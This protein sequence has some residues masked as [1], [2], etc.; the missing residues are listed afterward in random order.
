MSETVFISDNSHPVDDDA[1]NKIIVVVE[2]RCHCIVRGASVNWRAIVTGCSS[3]WARA[4]TANW[5]LSRPCCTTPSGWYGTL[6]IVPAWSARTPPAAGHRPGQRHRA[7]RMAGYRRPA[8]SHDNLTDTHRPS[9]RRILFECGGGVADVSQSSS[10]CRGFEAASDTQWEIWPV[11]T[12]ACDS[13]PPAVISPLIYQRTPPVAR[14]GPEAVATPM[15][16]AC[17]WACAMNLASSTVE[18]PILF[19]F[20]SFTQ[21]ALR[22]E[23]FVCNFSLPTWRQRLHNIRYCSR[24]YLEYWLFHCKSINRLNCIRT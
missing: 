7:L 5:S 18:M 14:P 6:D 21:F 9:D 2:L 16:C 3:L 20:N 10:S 11:I 1:A 24:L 19:C 8:V 12:Y 15:H 23:F 4:E 22:H 17:V 13:W